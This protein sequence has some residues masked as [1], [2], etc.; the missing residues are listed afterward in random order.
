MKTRRA[1]TLIELLV[2]IAII[3]ILAAMLLPAL[4][5]AKDRAK[6]IQCLN[7]IKQVGTYHTL[8]VTD[9]GRF[10]NYV[11]EELWMPRLFHSKT[12]PY[13]PLG[14]CPKAPSTGVTVPP[15]TIAEGGL[16]RPW[17]MSSWEGS[18]GFNGHL[19][20][21]MSDDLL[22][23]FGLHPEN[24]FRGESTIRSPTL[25]PVFFDAMW[26]DTWPNATD[27]PPENLVDPNKEPAGIQRVVIP[28]HGSAP[29]NSALTDFNPRNNLPGGI[30]VMFY[31][32]HAELV[33]LENLWTLQWN[34]NWVNPSVRPG[35]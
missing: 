14:Y 9:E 31:D 12:A 27:L 15:N 16:R 4:G 11:F 3:G 34:A 18:I 6:A 5:K 17:Q 26:P 29:G 25:T 1:F 19:Y 24:Q 8:Y 35:K 20:R 2:V 28:R 13:N 10:I 22:M 21:D 30:N 7:N 32:G 23:Q 33:K